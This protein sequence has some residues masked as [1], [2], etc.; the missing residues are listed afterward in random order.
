M[1]QQEIYKDKTDYKQ[2]TLPLLIALTFICFLTALGGDFVNIGDD[3]Y[4]I[5]NPLV[6]NL[7][8]N[9]IVAMFTMPIGDY[10]VF[11]PLVYWSYA[12][13]HSLWGMTAKGYHWTNLLLHLANIALV[14]RLANLLTK[15]YAMTLI[16][17]LLFAIHPMR[18]EAVAW[19][20]ARTEVLST[21]FLL[22]ALL[23]YTQYTVSKNISKIVLSFVL[24]LLA[25]LSKPVVIAFPLVFFLIDYWQERKFSMAVFVEKLPFL[26]VSIGLGVLF[27]M[28]STPDNVWGDFSLINKIVMACTAITF[29][30]LAPFAP[31]DANLS[32]AHTLP[33][34][35][36][37]LLPMPYYLSILFLVALAL[38]IFFVK[39]T[40]KELL[41]AV[42][43]VVINVLLVA[44]IL[45]YGQ[46]VIADRHAYFA[47]LGWFLLVAAAVVGLGNL[48]NKQIMYAVI[49]IFALFCV[50]QTFQ[51]N[52]IWKESIT[53]WIDIAVKNPDYYYGFFGLGNSQHERKDYA[54]AIECFNRAIVL[55]PKFTKAYYNRGVSYYA[56]GNF[57]AASK[58]FFKVLQDDIGNADAWLQAANSFYMM[59]DYNKAIN[60]YGQVIRMKPDYYP[61]YLYR[62]HSKFAIEDKEGACYDFGVV[63]KAGLPDGERLWKEA[64]CQ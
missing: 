19:I 12:I 20:S 50:V 52:Q 22:L 18:V 3:T 49:G 34:V 39:K 21:F 8:F 63:K 43:F 16:T 48:I 42:G 9:S 59:K 11:R 4:L 46:F 30:L 14:F 60:S 33:K 29:Y 58:D 15:N 1:H 53:V 40:R 44:T 51:R 35:V 61:A 41:F 55:E 37:G 47:H 27:L 56:A 5:N 24:F 17:A 57:Q 62:G 36:N 28:N 13:E 23:Q 31:V 25:F 7:S 6:K 45:P 2:Y 32:V 26:L 64:G 54:R 10:Q 38:I